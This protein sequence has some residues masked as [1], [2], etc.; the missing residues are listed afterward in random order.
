MRAAVQRGFQRVEIE[1]AALVR[2]EHDLRIRA[3]RVGLHG[4]DGFRVEPRCKQRDV[5]VSLAAHGGGFRTSG[6]AVVDGGVARIHAGELAEHGL[7]LEDRLQNALADLR[8]IG[9]IRGDKRF[10]CGNAAHHGGDMVPVGARSAKDRVKHAV[11][12]R[13]LFHLFQRFKF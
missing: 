11:L 3:K 13:E 5:A 8:L 7:V 12:F 6:C 1:P 9:R 2:N 4:L 10:L